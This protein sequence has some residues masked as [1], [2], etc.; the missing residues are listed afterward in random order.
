MIRLYIGKSAAGKDTALQKDLKKGFS[1]IISCTTR[2]KRIGEKE[3]KDYHFIDGT[4]RN[5]IFL[6]KAANGEFIEYREYSTCVG[7]IRDTWYYGTPILKD[8]ES[9]SY[10]GVVDIQGAKD[11]INYYKSHN[12][13]VDI[14]LIY[15]SVPEAERKRR[16]MS[17]GSFD[18][19]EWNRRA[20]ADRRDFSNKALDSLVELIP[21]IT[22][23]DYSQLEELK[24]LEEIEL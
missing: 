2:P 1:P 6:K 17:R 16:A 24:D 21:V 4:D 3:G 12:S 13:E 9:I 23:S 7:N 19:A 22:I 10:V 18:E 8:A 5:E 11:I 15:I 20:K 14:E